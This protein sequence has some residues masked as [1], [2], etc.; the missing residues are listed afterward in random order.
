LEARYTEYNIGNYA[1]SFHLSSKIDQDQRGAPR[2]RDDFGAQIG[3][4]KAA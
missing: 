2:R 4:G 1:R 3:K